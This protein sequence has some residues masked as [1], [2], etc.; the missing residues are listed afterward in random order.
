MLQRP[1]LFFTN[2]C[3][4]VKLQIYNPPRPG[5]SPLSLDFGFMFTANKKI[6]SVTFFQLI[7]VLGAWSILGVGGWSRDGTNISLTR[8][9]IHTHTQQHT[10]SLS[11]SISNRHTHCLSF[12]VSLTQTA[13]QT[14]KKIG[15]IMLKSLLQIGNNQSLIYSG[16]SKQ[17]KYWKK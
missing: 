17:K 5:H 7:L 10:H 14:R 3:I 1:K 12:S 9:N 16:D 11:I 15:K 4:N 13:S 2:F 6:L 8:T